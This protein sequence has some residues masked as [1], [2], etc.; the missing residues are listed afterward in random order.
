MTLA[1]VF[2]MPE[3]DK[4]K[5]L[6]VKH[7]EKLAVTSLNIVKEKHLSLTQSTSKQAA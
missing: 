6:Q 1:K 5:T 3:Q 2:F 7:V 4:D